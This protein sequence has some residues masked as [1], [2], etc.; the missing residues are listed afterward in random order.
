MATVIHRGDRQDVDKRGHRDDYRPADR[1]GFAPY[2][3]EMALKGGF[4]FAGESAQIS[5][6]SVGNMFGWSISEL[7]SL[8]IIGVVGGRYCR[9]RR[10]VLT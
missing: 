5:A 6:L 3:T 8:G 4:S 10:A 2:F 7:M 9:Q 1:R